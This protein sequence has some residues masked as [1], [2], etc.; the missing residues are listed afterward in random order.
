MKSSNKKK[1]EQL[2][3]PI[4]TAQNRLRKSIMFAMMR[5]LNVDT[6]H[7][8]NEAIEDIGD[9]SI[10][11]VDAWLDSDDPTAKFFDLNNIAFSH[12]SCNSSARRYRNQHSKQSERNAQ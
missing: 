4:G 8:C 7:Q 2:G 1:S 11:H 9:L 12:L 3:M 10:E 5:Q 6:C